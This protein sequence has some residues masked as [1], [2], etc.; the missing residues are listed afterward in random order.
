MSSQVCRPDIVGPP[1]CTKENRGR[2]ER[3]CLRYS[4]DLTDDEWKLVELV[5]S[6][7]KRGGADFSAEGQIRARHQSGAGAIIEI[8]AVGTDAMP[9]MEVRLSNFTVANL[10]T[11]PT[12]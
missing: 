5:I 9:E 12:S 8:D 4:R 7:G 3:S 2:Y 6:P 1:M 11:R 10:G